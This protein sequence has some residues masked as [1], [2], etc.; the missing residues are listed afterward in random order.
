MSSA[1][2]VTPAWTAGPGGSCDLRGGAFLGSVDLLE[3]RVPSDERRIADEE[4][5]VRRFRDENGDEWDVVLGHAS[6]GVFQALFIPVGGGGEEI[7][8]V[9]LPEENRMSASRKLADLAGDELRALLN[10]AD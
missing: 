1:P 5:P 6:W 9:V 4:G 2:P 7:R 8:S 10:R 3:S